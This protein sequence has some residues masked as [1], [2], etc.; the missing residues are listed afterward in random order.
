MHHKWSVCRVDVNFESIHCEQDH[1]LKVISLSLIQP[2]ST[3]DETLWGQN[4]SRCCSGTKLVKRFCLFFCRDH[5][6]SDFELFLDVWL[7]F[8]FISIGRNDLDY[9]RHIRGGY[10][11]FLLTFSYS[12][13]FKTIT[14]PVLKHSSWNVTLPLKTFPFMY[15][16]W[17]FFL[18]VFCVHV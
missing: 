12:L 17:S 16:Y 14:F 9:Q 7:L 18:K 15:Y 8:T 5:L 3:S 4:M 6:I 10:F 1:E 11:H 13:C 2:A